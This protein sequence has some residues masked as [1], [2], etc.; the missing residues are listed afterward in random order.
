MMEMF[1]YYSTGDGSTSFR[2]PNI[3][4]Y[5]RGSGYTSKLLMILLELIIEMVYHN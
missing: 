3:N 1:P 2:V 4:V 5:V